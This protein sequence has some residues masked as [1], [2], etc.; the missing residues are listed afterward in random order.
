MPPLTPNI[1]SITLCVDELMQ[2]LSSWIKRH[3]FS[4]FILGA[5]LMLGSNKI[6]GLTGI[7]IFIVGAGIIFVNKIDDFKKMIDEYHKQ[8]K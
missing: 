6:R 3:P 7:L 5:A 4:S 2:M 8:K 1:T